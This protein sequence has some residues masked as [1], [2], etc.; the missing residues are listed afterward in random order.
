MISSS[1]AITSNA[2]SLE[3]RAISTATTAAWIYTTIAASRIT[4]AAKAPVTHLV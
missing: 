3:F 1:V 4:E 2:K